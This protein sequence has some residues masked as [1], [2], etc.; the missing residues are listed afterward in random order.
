VEVAEGLRALIISE[1]S[2]R[3]T[4]ASTPTTTIMTAFVV[5]WPPPSK[6]GYGLKMPSTA[7]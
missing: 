6:E 2:G 4:G 1:G 7:H 5:S 3:R